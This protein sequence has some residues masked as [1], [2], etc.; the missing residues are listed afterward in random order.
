MKIFFRLINISKRF[1]HAEKKYRLPKHAQVLIYDVCNYNIYEIYLRPYSVELLH[2]R[3]E[4]INLAL[5]FKVLFSKGTLS[6]NYKNAFIKQVNPQLILTFIDNDINFYKI[7]L[8]H[9][10]P[11]TL[12][13]QNGW[14]GYYADIFEKLDSLKSQNILPELKVDHM[15]VFG[16]VISDEYKKYISGNTME[17]GSLRNNKISK[18]NKA[19]KGQ[20][21]FISQWCSG[22]IEMNNRIYSNDE[23]FYEVD[24]LALKFLREYAKKNNKILKV[25]PRYQSDDK[26]ISMEK[27]Y[28]QRIFGNED[29]YLKGESIKS[30]YDA[31]DSSEVVVTI[32]STLGYESF[33]RGNKT[34]F[35]SFR[36][37][38]LNAPGLSFAWPKVIPEFGK[39]WV[40][41]YDD[42]RLTAVMDYLFTADSQ[43]WLSEEGNAFSKELITLDPG[44]EKLQKLIKNLI[45][46]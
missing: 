18:K 2:V 22:S 45:S 3:G 9:P 34:A 25:I 16:K 6:E 44:N 33:I 17:I 43:S 4:V 14:R 31:I 30:A 1:W 29:V 8:K 27:S 7:H 10:T 15:L 40:N 13:F 46:Q 12:F 21:G 42:Q 36:G 37:D 35:F 32:D 5:L 19:Q 38:K 39:F 24:V 41:R 11:K 20:I 23:F 28:Y 26:L